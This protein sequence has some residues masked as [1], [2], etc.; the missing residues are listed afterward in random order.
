MKRLGSAM[1]TAVSTTHGVSGEV[2]DNE[3]KESSAPSARTNPD[4][5]TGPTQEL[6]Q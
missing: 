4:A 1:F 5:S 3:R 6:S 2:R